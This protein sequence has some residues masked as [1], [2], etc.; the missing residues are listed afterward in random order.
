L[1]T[2]R[3]GRSDITVPRLC[4][5]GMQASAW[6]SCTKDDY[7]AMASMAIDYGLTFIDT[8]P[9]YGAGE[10][11]RTIGEIIRGRRDS[12]IISTKFDHNNSDRTRIRTSLEGSLRRLAT[13]YVDILFQHWPSGKVNPLETIEEL[14]RLRAEG[15]IRAIGVSNW[16]EPEWNRLGKSYDIDCVQ[17]CYNLLWRTVERN[18]L[19]LC[20]ERQMSFL[21]YSSLCQGIL[22]SD[23]SNRTLIPSDS[24]ARNLR[25]KGKDLQESLEIYNIVEAIGRDIGRT[26]SQVALR[27]LLDTRGVTSLVVGMSSRRQVVENIG[28][29]DWRLPN[30][31]YDRLSEATR[32]L[33]ARLGP[34]DTLWGWHSLQSDDPR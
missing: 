3:V 11:E 30:D 22:A 34:H 28:V 29:M 24:R 17:N 8:A 31:C 32:R 20:L 10:S 4:I 26:P 27:W 25:L 12:V 18:I 6:Q 5:G 16:M 19:P 9:S 33:S 21:S 15:K 23:R 1:E 14:M 7:V 13:D 2:A